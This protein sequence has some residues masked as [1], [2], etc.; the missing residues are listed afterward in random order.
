MVTNA[1]HQELLGDYGYYLDLCKILWQEQIL[2]NCE[3][4]VEFPFFELLFYH[5]P[6]FGEWTREQSSYI[7]TDFLW[8][9]NIFRRDQNVL[10]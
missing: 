4:I 8:F 10:A 3:F 6:V 9:C 7:V 1:N 2:K 5:K